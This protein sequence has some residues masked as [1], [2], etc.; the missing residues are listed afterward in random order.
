M[1]FLLPTFVFAIALAQSHSTA[2]IVV[3]AIFIL[4]DKAVFLPLAALFAVTFVIAPALRRSAVSGTFRL[5]IGALVAFGLVFVR[6]FAGIIFLVFSVL[7]VRIGIPESEHESE[8]EAESDYLFHYILE[9]V[10]NNYI[11]V[12]QSVC[13]NCESPPS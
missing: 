4:V 10:S 9:I 8:H 6:S 11:L 12:K 2:A 3:D 5:C 7:R 1:L 13:H